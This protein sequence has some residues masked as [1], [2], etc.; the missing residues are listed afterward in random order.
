MWFASLPG[1]TQVGRD[2]P[3][4]DTNAAPSHDLRFLWSACTSRPYALWSSPQYLLG[5]AT[6]LSGMN[7]SRGDHSGS[8]RAGAAFAVASKSPL[9]RSRSSGPSVGS[10]W[11]S[12]T[13]AAPASPP[14]SPPAS[15]LA[16]GDAAAPA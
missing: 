8:A 1:A 13:S 4:N 2:H 15:A 7:G 10:T 6:S 11:L 5:S 14:A 12:A 3:S 9:A 16:P